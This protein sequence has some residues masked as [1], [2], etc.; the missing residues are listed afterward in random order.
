VATVRGGDVFY[1][2][3]RHVDKLSIFFRADYQTRTAP[4]KARKAGLAVANKI[5]ESSRR[6]ISFGPLGESLRPRRTSELREACAQHP[7]Y[8]SIR[9]PA[10]GRSCGDTDRNSCFGRGGEERKSP[11]AFQDLAV[12]ARRGNTPT[13]KMASMDIFLFGS[14]ERL[15]TRCWLV[16]RMQANRTLTAETIICPA[17]GRAIPFTTVAPGRRGDKLPVIVIHDRC[18]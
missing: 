13:A 5:V 4:G 15:L 9:N 3:N 11:R 18:H 14:C 16:T 12:I 7:T 2:G 8:I 6:H 1:V 17:K 10:C